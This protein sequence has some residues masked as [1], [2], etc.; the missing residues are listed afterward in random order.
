M[1]PPK[2]P[3]DVSMQSASYQEGGEQMRLVPRQFTIEMLDAVLSKPRK[4][5]ERKPQESRPAA[6]K[7]KT[8][9]ELTTPSDRGKRYLVFVVNSVATTVTRDK[10]RLDYRQIPGLDQL[11][12]RELAE[13][14]SR[15]KLTGRTRGRWHQS[16][17]GRELAT[18]FIVVMEEKNPQ[19][20]KWFD[21]HGH[22]AHFLVEAIAF[23]TGEQVDT[24]ATIKRLREFEGAKDNWDALPPA[25]EAF[26]IWPG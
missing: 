21:N 10:P 13:E 8:R 20:T 4:I 6:R 12:P 7:G 2:P 15:L 16:D 18:A 9:T 24:P 22:L 17:V 11:A 1:K 26:A 5:P 25:R 14:L 3:W 23:T 19:R